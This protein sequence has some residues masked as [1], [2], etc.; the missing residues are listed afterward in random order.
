[1]KLE[2]ENKFEQ[3]SL[4]CYLCGLGMTSFG[5]LVVYMGYLSQV[6]RFYLIGL[7]MFMAGYAFYK[8]S[9]RVKYVILSERRYAKYKTLES[10]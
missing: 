7:Y 8:I 2:N 3:L 5:V 4:Y 1:M 10:S 6:D 9:E